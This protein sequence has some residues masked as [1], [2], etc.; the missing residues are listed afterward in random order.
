MDENTDLG[1]T[2]IMVVTE[3]MGMEEMSLKHCT[4]GKEKE[5]MMMS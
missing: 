4:V 2:N 5:A 1:S 3:I